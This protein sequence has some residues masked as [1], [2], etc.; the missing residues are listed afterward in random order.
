M[1]RSITAVNVVE[2]PFWDYPGGLGRLAHDLCY[3]Q[4]KWGYRVYLVGKKFSGR[5]PDRE[6]IDGITVLRM[7]SKYC[8]SPDPRNMM[9]RIFTTRKAVRRAREEA[10]QIDLVHTHTPLHGVAA[11]KELSR[12]GTLKVNSIHSPWL[13]EMTAQNLWSGQRGIKNAAR[14]FLARF[15][16]KHIEAACFSRSDFITADSE[17]T[18][19]QITRDY[20]KITGA[21]NFQVLPGWVDT[22]RFSPEGPRTDWSPE[23]G[24]TPRGPVFFTVRGLKPRN[25]LELLIQAAA[26]VKRAGQDFDLV[27]GG[28]GALREKLEALVQELKL[29]DR[30]KLLGRVEDE[31]LPVL[32]RSCDAF[33]LPTISLECFGIIILEA[34][35]SGK[36]VIATPVGAIPELLAPIYPEGLISQVSAGSLAEAM[37]AYLREGRHRIPKDQAD[38]FRAYVHES[39]SLEV[40][41]D[42]FRKIYESRLR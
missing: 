19:T 17:Y 35:A 41:T 29:T 12:S 2:L 37:I 7:T 34:L 4:V 40:G 33:V 20:G 31:R 23:L 9:E 16:A 15:A 22:S 28:Q 6:E 30:V 5:L 21:K 26:L 38:R 39:Y 36:P 10:G 18:R 27:I 11:L 14:D 25:G 8:P 32:Y 3:Q 24:R 42:R 13:M 1:S